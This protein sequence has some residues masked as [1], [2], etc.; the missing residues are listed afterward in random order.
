MIVNV[1]VFM[2]CTNALL[3]T[4]GSDGAQ[5]SRPVVRIVT[6]DM[7]ERIE[8]TLLKISMQKHVGHKMSS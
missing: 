8:L 1:F 6:E 2:Y 3:R 4:Q 5:T 7:M